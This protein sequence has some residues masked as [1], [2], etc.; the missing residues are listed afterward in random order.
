MAMVRKAW[1]TKPVVQLKCCK[2]RGSERGRG[3]F[4]ACHGRIS[5]SI[6]GRIVSQINERP[7]RKRKTKK[8]DTLSH[9]SIVFLENV[10][11]KR[12]GVSVSSVLDEMIQ[13]A[14]REQERQSLGQ[15]VEAYYS[16]L[17]NQEAQELEA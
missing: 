14:L 10:S 8:S 11:K 6:Q 15:A 3:F 7:N 1:T 4:V 5:S 16:G 9:D 12:R 2:S 13:N 17:S